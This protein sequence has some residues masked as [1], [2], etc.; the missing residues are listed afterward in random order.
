MICRDLL[1]I[2]ED[3]LIDEPS[4][5]QFKLLDLSDRGGLKYPSELVLESIVSAWKIFVSIENDNEMM[6]LLVEGPSRNI[7][8][9]LSM[10]YILNANVCDSWIMYARF[11]L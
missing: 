10:N 11:V 5:S 2:D 7:L 9:D 8:V 1:T 6:A 3:L 4:L